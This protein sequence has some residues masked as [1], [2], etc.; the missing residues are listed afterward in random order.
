MS[1]IRIVSHA[2]A[3]SLPQ[4]AVFLRAQISSLI[5]HPPVTVR[6]E[7][8]VCYTPDD[9]RIRRVLD[10]FCGAIWLTPLALDPPS[11][12]RRA[13]GRNQVAQSQQADLVWFADVDHCFGEGCLDDA[14]RGWSMLKPKPGMIWPRHV[15]VHA[16]HAI[17]DAFWQ[18]HEQ[19]SG[20]IS[21]SPDQFVERRY[22]RPIGGVQIVGG[23]FARQH[24]YLPGTKW[25]TPNPKPFG[26]FR[27]DTNFK[28]VCRRHGGIQSIEVRNLFRLRH[29]AVTYKATS[30]TAQ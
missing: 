4:F 25:M 10:E 27:D 7:L 8:T 14:W 13:I 2:Y 30:P 3:A 12:F 5:L 6:F 28:H 1:M 21:V 19:A 22:R 16:D 17:G 26:D 15:L 23:D 9:E 29:S 11:L 18:T 24:G 20:C